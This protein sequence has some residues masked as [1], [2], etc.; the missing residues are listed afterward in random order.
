[1]S[2]GTFITL[3]KLKRYSPDNCLLPGQGIKQCLITSGMGKDKQQPPWG[4]IKTKQTVT[5]VGVGV[6]GDEEGVG[7]RLFPVPGRE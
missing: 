2:I 1:M 4:R 5:G 6:G 3:E 7:G